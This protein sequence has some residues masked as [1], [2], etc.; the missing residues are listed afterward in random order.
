MAKKVWGIKIKLETKGN[1]LRYFLYIAPY[2]KWDTKDLFVTS[3][4]IKQA[5]K[6]SNLT[7]HPKWEVGYIVRRVNKAKKT[8]SY[9]SFFPFVSLSSNKK[10]AQLFKHEGIAVRVERTIEKDLVRRYPDYDVVMSKVVTQSREAHLKKRGLKLG[11]RLP[12]KEVYQ[13]TR[14][15]IKKESK[16]RS[17]KKKPTQR[18]PR[19]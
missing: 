12:L 18:R 2:D 13:I 3:K 16:K 14:D 4:E 6:E 19:K 10:L 17:K 1:E 8:I 9:R 15:Y 5:I 7:V 11:Q